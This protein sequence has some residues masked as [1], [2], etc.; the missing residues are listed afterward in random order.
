M[1]KENLAVLI[2]ARANARPYVER[3]VWVTLPKADKPDDGKQ[4]W[5]R[6]KSEC[7]LL[8]RKEK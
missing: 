1:K 6:F 4:E 8:K 3:K 5:T 2:Q 7:V